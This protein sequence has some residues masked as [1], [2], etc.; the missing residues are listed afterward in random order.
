MAYNRR[1][2]IG[3]LSGNAGEH[4]CAT[5]LAEEAIDSLELPRDWLYDETHWIWGDALVAW[6]IHRGILMG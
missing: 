4:L 6:N 3:W 2:I 5:H 1:Y